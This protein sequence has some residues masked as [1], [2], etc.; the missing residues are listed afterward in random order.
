[1]M[2]GMELI[3]DVDEAKSEILAVAAGER[4]REEFEAWIRSRTVT[5]S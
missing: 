3:A 1:M 4:I 2:S 5:P